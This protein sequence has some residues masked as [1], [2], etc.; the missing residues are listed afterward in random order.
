MFT[1]KPKNEN[2]KKKLI[3]RLDSFMGEI[4]KEGVCVT[5]GSRQNLGPGHYITRAEMSLRWDS[6]NV[7]P[8]CWDCNYKHE[9][10]TDPYDRYMVRTYGPKY[11]EI[12]DKKRR[13][14]TKFSV[15]DL[16]NILNDLK[17]RYN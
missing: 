13:E 14:H 2:K 8:Q 3:K 11:K 15:L 1:K 6:M 9:F 7:H 12:L 5:C 16:E 17:S 4:C 10:N